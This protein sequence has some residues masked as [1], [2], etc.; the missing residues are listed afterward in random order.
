MADKVVIITKQG[1]VIKY[2]PATIP[3]RKRGGALL[4]GLKLPQGD[5]VV[6]ITTVVED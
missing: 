3:E 5:E 6:G 4:K 1:Q 2:D